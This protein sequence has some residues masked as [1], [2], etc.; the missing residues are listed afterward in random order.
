MAS[1]LIAQPPTDAVDTQDANGM[2]SPPKEGWRNFFG[3]VF[4]ICLGVTQSGPTAQRPVSRLWTGRPYF[5]TTLGKP[6]WLKSTFPT[7][8]VDGTGVSV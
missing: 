5:D 3:N 4:N 1:P 6:V 7:V 8:W 2:L